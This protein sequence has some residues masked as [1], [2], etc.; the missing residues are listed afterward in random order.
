VLTLRYDILK[1]E[2]PPPAR[3]EDL[4]RKAIETWT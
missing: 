4:A 3:L 2:V 1:A